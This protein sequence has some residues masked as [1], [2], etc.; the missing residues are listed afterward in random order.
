MFHT[1]LLSVS[2]HSSNHQLI[3]MIGMQYYDKMKDQDH[4]DVDP[5]ESKVRTSRLSHALID[6]YFLGCS[7]FIKTKSQLLSLL[8]AS[9][10]SFFCWRDI[11]EVF[12]DGLLIKNRSTKS[13]LSC[14]ESDDG[15]ISPKRDAFSVTCAW[16]LCWNANPR[17]P[18]LVVSEEP[19]LE[20]HSIHDWKTH[21]SFHSL[22]LILRK[23]FSNLKI[24]ARQQHPSASVHHFSI[25]GLLLVNYKVFVIRF[26]SFPFPFLWSHQSQRSIIL[27]IY[28]F[29][30]TQRPPKEIHPQSSEPPLTL[31]NPHE[32]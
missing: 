27:I 8:L 16:F 25:Y 30:D 31:R 11:G 9:L 12:V 2:L 21:S 7:D 20:A 22:S 24:L 10:S 1:P 32:I 15:Q 5:H 4:K 18:M 23:S 6:L 17:C 29:A 19:D 28:T 14:L 3:Q 26:D 13:D